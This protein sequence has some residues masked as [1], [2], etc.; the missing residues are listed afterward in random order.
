MDLKKAKIEGQMYDV[1]S[2]ETLHQSPELYDSGPIA[3]EMKD[4]DGD[5]VIL[6]Y[7]FGLIKNDK[8][9]GVYDSGHVIEQFVYPTK[10]NKAEYQPETIDF[11]NIENIQDYIEKHSQMKG[12]EREILAGA[13]DVYYPNVSGHESA[14]MKCLKDAIIAK[15]IDIDKYAPRFGSDFQNT[16]RKLN[17]DTVTLFQLKRICKGL[18]M[19]VEIVISDSEGEIANP[20]GRELRVDLTTTCGE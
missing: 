2:L 12:I 18:D 16:K 6:P 4:K 10:N 15:R 20:I 8:V 17:D 9:P 13:S 3:I 19:K 11:S 14:E 7:R 5:T 1:I